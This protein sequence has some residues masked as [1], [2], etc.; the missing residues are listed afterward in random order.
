MIN[1]KII[2][3]RLAYNGEGICAALALTDKD[4]KPYVIGPAYINL[5]NIAEILVIADAPSWEELIGKIV[6]AEIENDKVVKIV[7]P[8][9]D[10]Y[11]MIF[12]PGEESNT[13]NTEAAEA[14]EN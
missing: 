9:N 5:N 3:T 6:Q 10:E 11:E 1:M 8:L 2:G 12:I 13:E 14:V 7:N 4:N